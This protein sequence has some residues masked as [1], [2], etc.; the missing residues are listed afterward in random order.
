[1]N[2]DRLLAELR[3]QILSQ[4]WVELAKRYVTRHRDWDFLTEVEGLLPEILESLQGAANQLQQIR[5]D[6]LIQ[7]RL[8]VLGAL[9]FGNNPT[10]HLIDGNYEVSLM[11]GKSFKDSSQILIGGPEVAES[12]CGSCKASQ[13]LMKEGQVAQWPE[14]RERI[15]RLLGLIWGHLFGFGQGSGWDNRVFHLGSPKLD[16]NSDFAF[17]DPTVVI[18]STFHDIQ[19]KPI[20]LACLEKVSLEKLRGLT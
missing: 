17:C 11:C 2:R 18:H 15:Q 3:S 20:C 8:T 1:M 6:F 12:L 19:E 10:Y 13:T 4:E 14:G 7:D 9:C 16:G 5:R